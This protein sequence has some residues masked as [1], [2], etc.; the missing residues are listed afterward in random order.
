MMIKPIDLINCTQSKVAGWNN[1]LLEKME[2]LFNW[3]SIAYAR[4]IARDE[5]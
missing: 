5:S 1:N 3:A 2:L 4:S